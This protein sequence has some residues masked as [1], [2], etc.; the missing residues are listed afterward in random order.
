MNQAS[1]SRGGQKRLNVEQVR[2]FHHDH[3]V[4]DQVADFLAIAATLAAR[5]PVV[6]MGGG[7]GFF[8]SALQASAGLSTSVVDMDAASIEACHDKG[9]EGRLGDALDPPIDGDEAVVCFNLILHH[10][11]GSTDATTRALQSRA[12]AVWRGRAAGLFVN[13]YIY[14]AW[15]APRVSAWLIWQVTSS[16]LFST[17]G[18]V[19]ARVVPSLSANT[20][21]VGVRFR[22]SSDW[23]RLFE[24]CG[25]QVVRTCRGADEP[26]SLA[27]RLLLIRSCRRDSYLLK[28]SDRRE[29]A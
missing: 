13:E 1:Q 19:V 21:G 23:E 29:P 3:F 26:V 16:R 11:V 28:A 20:F 25:F 6:D 17:I 2:E 10:L 24:E 27:R 4:R 14:E 9:V 15:L 12:L 18:K 5:G 22:A 8:A 7:C